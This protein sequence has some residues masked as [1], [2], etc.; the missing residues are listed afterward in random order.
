MVYGSEIRQ[1]PL[2]SDDENYDDGADGNTPLPDD[3]EPSPA[4]IICARGKAYW[5]HVGNERY[6]KLIADATPKYSQTSNKLEKT[7]I[8]SEIVQA[9]HK[10]NGKFIKRLK[11]GGPFVI[12]SE[13]FA[14][15]K[16]SSCI[17]GAPVSCSYF[18][19]PHQ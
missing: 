4:D 5:D 8:V 9:V 11:K 15:E 1:S 2:I 12:V 3:Y 7:M 18:S 13:V 6:R 19:A 14:R 10:T 17:S 16:V